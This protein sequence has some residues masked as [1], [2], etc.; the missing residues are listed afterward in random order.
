MESQSNH[1]RGQGV[2]LSPHMTIRQ[3]LLLGD[4]LKDHERDYHRKTYA[5]LA[6]MAA[7]DPV[8]GFTP[9]AQNMSS[10]CIARF[11]MKQPRIKRTV[12][13]TGATNERLADCE[14]RLAD[15]ERRLTEAGA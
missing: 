14:R 6:A 12:G 5:E 10:I 3:K 4:W 1:E 15:C 11:G 13:A 8:V 7:S 9:T 2:R